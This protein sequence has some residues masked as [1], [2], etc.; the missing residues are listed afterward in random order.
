[1]AEKPEKKV[2][3]ASVEAS[4]ASKLPV[5]VHFPPGMAEQHLENCAE[6]ALPE[7]TEQER[8]EFRRYWRERLDRER[9]QQ[10]RERERSE[11]AAKCQSQT[12][13]RNTVAIQTAGDAGGSKRGLIGRLSK[14]AMVRMEAGPA[15]DGTGGSGAGPNLRYPARASWLKARLR[16]RS[17]NKH[18]LS[19]H[20][21]PDHKT[22]QKILDGFSVREDVLQKVAD[23]LSKYRGKAN[24]P[25]VEVTDIPQD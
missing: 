24:L 16:E 19:R 7:G 4:L 6:K 10:G 17:W 8:A 20:A 3:R 21:G 23:G 14:E 9:E 11:R 22:T 2:P 5:L 12:F 15:A 1:M 13:R 18:D 25:K